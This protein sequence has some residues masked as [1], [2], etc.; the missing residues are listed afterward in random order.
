MEMNY[1]ERKYPGWRDS[2]L[3]RQWLKQG[4]AHPDCINRGRLE[5]LNKGL[6]HGWWLG[7]LVLAVLT[8]LFLREADLT[9]RLQVALGVLGTTIFMGAILRYADREFFRGTCGFFRAVDLVRGAF[10][11]LANEN[12][13]CGLR[14]L[15]MPHD[16]LLRAADVVLTSMAQLILSYE[17]LS[18][19]KG[20]EFGSDDQKKWDEAKHLF[21][22]A[23]E[24]LKV[25]GLTRENYNHYF[26]RARFGRGE[27]KVSP[28]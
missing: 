18:E 19:S 5:N 28:S 3:L 27:G 13:A 8:L 11:G 21:E 12:H 16:A 10:G 6:L 4:N 15:E 14:I 24:R 9:R 22:A 23:F 2:A 7:G 1:F 26:K 25:F 17:S 20:G